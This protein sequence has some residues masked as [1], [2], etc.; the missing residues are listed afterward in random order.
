VIPVE[1]E[2]QSSRHLP[3]IVFARPIFL[4]SR[5]TVYY[6]LSSPLI[7][8]FKHVSICT[9]AYHDV[10]QHPDGHR[11]TGVFAF[12]GNCDV[13]AAWTC[14]TAPMVRYQ[15]HRSC[16]LPDLLAEC[17]FFTPGR[18]QQKTS[19]LRFLNRRWK[20][21]QTS[22]PLENEGSRQGLYHEPFPSSSATSTCC[23]R[24]AHG[25]DLADLGGGRLL[26]SFSPPKAFNRSIALSMA[27]LPFLCPEYD[28]QELLA[29]RA[30]WAAREQPFTR[31]V[32][33]WAIL[34]PRVCHR[35]EIVSSCSASGK[36]ILRR[37][38]RTIMVENNAEFMR[39]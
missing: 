16:T 35:W 15:D 31:P 28:R 17:R 36:A 7:P 26:I 23:F 12:I 18:S 2:I 4:Q 3:H 20:W 37:P 32:L 22:L 30:P 9:V 14:V 13:L 10:V 11:L 21:E 5:L 24:R 1:K 33:F 39:K 8:F 6:T 38:V 27:F 29:G 34:D 25:L 19:F